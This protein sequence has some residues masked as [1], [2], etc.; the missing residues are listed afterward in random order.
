MKPVYA[1]LTAALVLTFGVAACV[2]R[3]A[4]PPAPAPAAPA[5][6]VLPPAPGP[7]PAFSNWKDAPRTLGEWR[8]APAPGGGTAL[9]ADP[10]RG[11]RFTLRC[12]RSQR[13]IVLEQPG[14][15]SGAVP[16]VVRTDALNRT[17]AGQA[18]PGQAGGV[19][20]TLPATDPLLDAMALSRGR[21]AVEAAGQPP[22]YLPSWPEVT[23]V[24]EDCRG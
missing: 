23:R 4:A 14:Q 7:A 12:D 24:V 20:V 15:A 6:T 9:Y 3:A 19:R 17:L 5:P 2:P 10:G 21:F 18:V 16:V 11:T 22:L 8:Y 13:Q 1:R